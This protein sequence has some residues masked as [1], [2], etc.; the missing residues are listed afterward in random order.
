M[1]VVSK[2]SHIWDITP[3]LIVLN[4]FYITNTH[5][6]LKVEYTVYLKEIGSTSTGLNPLAI[7]KGSPLAN[8][9]GLFHQSCQLG[10]HWSNF[11]WLEA[12]IKGGEWKDEENCYN[13]LIAN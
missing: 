3:S 4:S 5:N 2:V 9:I 12:S 11:H 8:I 6:S 7:T 13:V 1:N 10:L